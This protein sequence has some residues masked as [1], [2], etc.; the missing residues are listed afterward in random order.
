MPPKKGQRQA[1]GLARQEQILDVAF[2]LF[3][4]LGVRATTIAAVAERV[5]LSEAGLLHHFPSKDDLLLAVLNRADASFTDTEAWV[6]EPRGG[7]E[8]LRRL[9]ATA[10]VLAD[11]PMLARLRAI[12]SAESIV[13][14]GAAR[15]YVQ[16]RTEIIR[17]VLAESLDA[18]VQRGELRSDIDPAI[19]ATEI[20]AFMEGIQ[21]QW[22]LDPEHIDFVKS[23]ESFVAS[24]VEQ[25]AVS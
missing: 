25:I 23:Y 4:T 17:Q 18:G 10:H 11:R 7:L 1:R 6:A 12:V 19:R 20:V 24:L 22:M 15:R 16:Q 13:Q 8:S 2:E 3:A 5:G 9:P 21:V 14:D